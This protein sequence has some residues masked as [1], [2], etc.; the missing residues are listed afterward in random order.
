[1]SADVFI[2]PHC[3]ADIRILHRDEH[4]LVLEKPHGLLSV[5]G[6][7]P[8]NVDSVLTR[9]KVNDPGVK[10]VHRLDFATSGLM[11]ACLTD[12]AIADLNRQFQQRTVSKSYTAVLAGHLQQSDFIIDLPIARAEF[13]RQRICAETGKSAQTHVELLETGVTDEG[14][15]FSRVLFRPVTGRTHQ[16]RLHS[17]AIGHPILGCDLYSMPV[18]AK[19][20]LVSSQRLAGRLMLHAAG[21][22]FVCPR[23]GEV[24]RFD[25]LFK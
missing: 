10:L 21:L 6:Q 25:S 19:A 7:N 2:A 12:Y 11:V 24:V 13:P 5:P 22:K 8:L 15:S 1:M 4:I 17:L 3:S 16:L 20:G 23:S 14:A 18:E 9:L